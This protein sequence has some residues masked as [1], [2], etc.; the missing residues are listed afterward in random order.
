MIVQTTASPV[1]HLSFHSQ[2]IDVSVIVQPAQ[3]LVGKAGVRDGKDALEALIGRPHRMCSRVR[4]L[5][6]LRMDITKQ[7][8]GTESSSERGGGGGVRK[9][10]ESHWTWR[11]F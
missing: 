6:Y 4:P 8:C 9:P 11:W 7:P 3:F 10:G 1:L 2:M 5:P